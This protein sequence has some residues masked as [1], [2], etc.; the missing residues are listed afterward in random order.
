VPSTMS[1]A[2][3]RES[4][5]NLS[6]P[7][8]PLEFFYDLRFVLKMIRYRFVTGES[9]HLTKYHSFG[10]CKDPRRSLRYCQAVGSGIS[11]L[12]CTDT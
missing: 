2:T 4:R 6:L 11:G 10:G 9:L 3:L 8:I 7:P 12:H 1:W 5:P